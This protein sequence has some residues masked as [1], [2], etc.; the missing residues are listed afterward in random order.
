MKH[1]LFCVVT[2]VVFLLWIGINVGAQTSAVEPTK[3]VEP[4]KNENEMAALKRRVAELEAQNLEMLKLLHA[5]NAKLELATAK[6]EEPKTEAKAM[7]ELG[8]P[9]SLPLSTKQE[10]A[11]T[12]PPSETVK[13][14]EV[15]AGNSKIKLYG[16]L[17][18]D[19]FADSQ[20]PNSPQT[21][22]F[23][24]S[25]DAAG[26]RAGAG[27]FS[28]SS[29]FTRLGIDFTG[30]RITSLG[31]AK[32]TGRYEMDFFGNYGTESR[33]NARIR[34][35]W[36]KLNWEH[37]SMT[38]GQD[39]QIVAPLLPIPNQT[40]DMFYAGNVG[41]RRPLIKTEWKQK[42]GAGTLF[43]Q[44]G[45]GLTGSSDAQDLDNDGYRDG[46]TSG[47]PHIEGRV[48]YAHSLWV[49]DKPITIGFSGL[50]GSEK[51]VRP[52]A[53]RTEFHPQLVAVDYVLPLTSKL[54]WRGE[55]WRGSRLTDFRGG[56]NQTM[57]LTTGRDVG[58][59][60]GWTELKLAPNRFYSLHTG[61]SI[62]DPFD[63]DLE[64]GGRTRN[65]SEYIGARVSPSDHFLLGLDFLHWRTDFKAQ[66]TG[67]NNRVNLIFQY[68]F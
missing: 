56:I 65:H 39:W 3:T 58:A 29:R 7:P 43:L 15:A 14:N 61:F 27:N 38:I 32:L 9:T 41:D 31:D 59:R 66:R 25:P 46:E 49:K 8:K 48:A 23:I 45:M 50:Y 22:Q 52:I 54:E 20:R 63:S 42:V 53:G 60:G 1:S 17:R 10:V 2:S 16:F 33:A 40:A 5:I 64:T 13:W 67:V 12:A 28:L 19:L 26:N 36:L 55:L 34:F 24:L 62:D 51:T 35:A 4:T 30:P 6:K 57:N 47:R 44:G 21:P 11:P 37:A 68:S 18:L